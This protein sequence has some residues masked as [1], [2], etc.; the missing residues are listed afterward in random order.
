MKKVLRSIFTALMLFTMII[1]TALASHAAVYK[2]GDT[3][4]DGEVTITDATVIQRVLAE[5]IEDTDGHIL[6]YGDINGNGLSIMDV[7]LIQRYLAQMDDGYPI[8]NI[9]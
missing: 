1:G 5:M 7:T 6:K 9:M 3:D 8:G 4:R 2:M